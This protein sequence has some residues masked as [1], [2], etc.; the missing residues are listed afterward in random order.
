MTGLTRKDQYRRMKAFDATV[1][2]K[3]EMIEQRILS[4]EKAA[5]HHEYKLEQVGLVAKTIYQNEF[6][7]HWG[8]E[9]VGSCRCVKR[10]I[11]EH[12]ARVIKPQQQQ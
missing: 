11:R 3:K 5:K 9:G 2:Q 1:L 12:N 10:I 8:M 4:G 7:G 6:G